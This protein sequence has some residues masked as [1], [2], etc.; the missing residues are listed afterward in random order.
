MVL[1]SAMLKLHV[2]RMKL[3]YFDVSPVNVLLATVHPVVPVS[4]P[5]LCAGAIRNFDLLHKSAILHSLIWE[6]PW[7]ATSVCGQVPS[8]LFYVTD[9]A[10]ALRFLVNIGAEVNVIHLQYLI[11]TTTSL[12]LPCRQSITHL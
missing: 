3:S 5:L 1:A 4:L 2:S 12:T 7:P 10:T 11:V 9:K 8:R 6:T